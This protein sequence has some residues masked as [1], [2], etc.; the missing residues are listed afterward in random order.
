M[1]NTPAGFKPK[2]SSALLLAACA[3]TLLSACG[4]GGGGGADGLATSESVPTLVSS[5]TTT[6]QLDVPG[7]P[8]GVAAQSA[9]PTFHVA[10]VLLN[11]PDD[12]DSADSAASARRGPR[13]QAV[14]A[15]FGNLSTRRLTVQAMESVRHMRALSAQ[16]PGA[17]DTRPT[18][19]RRSAPLTACRHCPQPARR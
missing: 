13:L 4:G 17:A 10:P 9:L 5:A 1:T 2:P 18:R 6:L 7:F 16:T 11:A 14:P 15:E 19:R 12:A 8:D 3:A